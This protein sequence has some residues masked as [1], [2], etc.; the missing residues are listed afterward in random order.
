MKAP[1]FLQCK[2][3]TQYFFFSWELWWPILL[4]TII[5]L[6]GR[7]FHLYLL[8]S[9][10]Q[11]CCSAV[12]HSFEKKNCSTWNRT[13]VWSR[14]CVLLLCKTTLKY[15]CCKGNSGNRCKLGVVTTTFCE[16]FLQHLPSHL[17]WQRCVP[18]ELTLA[19]FCC[20]NLVLVREVSRGGPGCDHSYNA[21]PS[22]VT[23][24]KLLLFLFI[25]SSSFFFFFYYFFS[26]CFFSPS[27][28]EED[29]G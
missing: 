1:K 6:A 20:W 27:N 24:L 12:S 16:Q 26:F 29:E 22:L 2:R 21:L 25:S 13:T 5:S 17:A 18:A 14:C 7:C 9:A 28:A 23:A 4:M 15:N 19:G 11:L 3:K 8:L 10:G